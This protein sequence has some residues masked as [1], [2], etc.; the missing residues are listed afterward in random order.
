MP[1]EGLL[2]ALA[3]IGVFVMWVVLPTKLRER[4]NTER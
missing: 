2:A 3:F 1:T 4:S